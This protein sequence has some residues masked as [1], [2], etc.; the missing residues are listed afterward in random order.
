VIEVSINGRNIEVMVIT[1]MMNGG[2]LRV[3]GG[4]RPTAPEVAVTTQ[5]LFAE[6]RFSNPAFG[7][8]VAGTATA[9][10]ITP[11]TNARASGV[12]VWFRVFGSDGTTAV[13]DGEMYADLVPDQSH[14]TQGGSLS[15][16]SLLF[17]RP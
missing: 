6:L 12:P 8:P 1:T 10:A 7:T 3:Y 17:S 16:S 5:V 2:Y 14:V 4:P 13:L 9:N 11:E 15:V